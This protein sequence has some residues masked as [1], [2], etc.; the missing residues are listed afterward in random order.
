VLDKISF[1][2]LE[3]NEGDNGSSSHYE[4]VTKW[5]FNVVFTRCMELPGGDCCIVPMVDYL[6]HGSDANV[7]ITYDDEGN[8]YVYSTRDVMAGEPLVF[9]YGDSSNPS[10]LMARYGFLDES[11]PGT[12]CKYVIENPTFEMFN[13]GYPNS[14]LF[15]NDGSISNEVW[16]VLLYELL[17]SSEEQ[18]TF[19]H[20]HMTGDEATKSTYHEQYFP[21]TLAVLQKHVEF[22]VSELDEAYIRMED[23]SFIS[24]V[25]SD[26]EGGHPRLPLISRHNNYV[27]GI[28]ELVK[29]YLEGMTC[30]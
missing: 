23:Q 24:S 27:R 22:L 25:D 15:Y 7:D 6:N 17:K 4:E 14:M 18:Q 19:Y 30:Y 12:F 9:P 2:S 3:K 28:V 11:S 16:D 21:Q 1:L 29:R 5:A 26:D 8:C 20:A 13:L 10:N